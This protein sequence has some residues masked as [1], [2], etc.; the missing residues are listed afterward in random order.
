[1][2]VLVSCGQQETE[3]PTPTEEVATEEPAGDGDDESGR[4]EIPEA[5]VEARSDYQIAFIPQ[6]IGIPYF[7]AMDEGGQEAAVTFGGE[8]LYTGAPEAD[9]AEQ[10]R[11]MENLIE[12]QVDAISV[13]VL[14]PASLNPVMERAQEAGIE[15]YTSDSDAPNSTRELYVAQAR[16]QDL[17][18]TLIDEL[19]RQIDESGQIGIVSG[20]ST[21]TNLNTWI[22]FMQERVDQEYPDIEI[23]DIRYTEGGSSEDALRQAQELMTRY[24]DIEGLIAVASTTVPGVARAVEQAGRTGEVAV[25][26][27]GSPNT[28][29]PFIESGVMEVSILWNPVDLGYLTHWAG[30]QLVEGYEFQEE[31]EVPGMENP[32]RYFEDEQILLL[33]PPLVIT[34]ENVDDF[35][36]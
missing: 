30:I 21:A 19:A 25:I 35:N 5:T 15:V 3:E 26:G 29:R 9:A 31:N 12:Q 23:V 10:V 20:E 16:D 36:F 1:M 2:L 27:Y 34:S 6:L 4:A 14:D 8:W 22:E 7:G 33:G 24:P 18:Y 17:G 32:V 13:S 11:L 28:V